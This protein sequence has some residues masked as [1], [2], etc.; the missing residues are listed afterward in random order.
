MRNNVTTSGLSSSGLLESFFLPLADEVSDARDPRII[1]LTAKADKSRRFRTRDPKKVYAL[2]LHQMAC[3]FKVRDPL[4]R[5]LKMAPH[6]AILPDGRILQ[7]HPV[8][9]LTGASNGFNAGSVAVEFAGNFPDTRGKWWHGPQNGQNQVTAAQI[10]AGRY[11]VRYLIRTMGLKVILAH[12]QSSGTRDNDPGPDVW[13]HVGQ[14]AVDTLGLKDGGPGFKIDTGKSIPDIWRTWGKAK[15]QPEFEFGG[16]ELEVATGSCPDVPVPASG[17][18]KLLKRGSKHSAVREVQRKLNAFHAYRLSAGLPGLRD[19][20]LAADCNFGE[21]TFEAVE[22]F[23]ELVFPG[24]PI[25]H[26][27]KVGPHTWAQLDAIV[28]GSGTS[29][30]VQFAVEQLRIVD[31]GFA[32]ALNWDQV[33]GLHTSSLNVEFVA[34]GLPPAV[35]PP[36][37]NIEI[38]SRAPNRAGGVAT[39]VTA[40]KLPAARFHRDHPPDPNK[41]TYRLSRPLANLSDFLKVERQRK[42]VTTIKRIG[43]TSDADFRRALG[44]NS[45]GIA[46]L[47]ASVGASSGSESREIP[48]AFTLFRSAGV[49]VIEVRVPAQPNWRVPGSVKRLVRSPADVVYYS[50]HG[51]SGSGKLVIDTKS[52]PCPSTQHGTYKDW[53]GPSDLIPV[54]TS[55]M[56]LDVLILA[57]CSVLRISFTSPPTGPGVKW[58][59]LLRAKGGPLAALLG[60]GSG[61]PCDSPNGARIAQQMAQRLK[62]GS[63]SFARDWLT[64]NGNNNANNAVAMDDRGYWWIEGTWTGGFDIKGPK[65][66]P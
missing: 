60:Y 14:W 5:F 49:E 53:L 29:P 41:I 37:I 65:A 47:P 54:W 64:V 42:E 33:I 40:L 23:Q 6:F 56:D 30:S 45:R 66:I 34:F 25:E 9:S 12:R 62:R 36:Q 17:R 4:T 7:L 3:C 2:V 51:L 11:L 38:S 20:P 10:E 55:P 39:L 50:G 46:T 18:P 31:D 43:G 13:Y 16:L 19:S 21:H 48:D 63:T 26:D 61:A 27:G 59:Q 15:P 44:W 28:V 58:S 57:G 8:L 1:D 35:M 32:S 22:S 24:M 52:L